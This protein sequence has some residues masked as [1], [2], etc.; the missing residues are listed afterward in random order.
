MRVLQWVV[1]RCE[2]KGGAVETP[3]GRM[4]RYEDLEW[5]GLDT[6]DRSRFEKLMKLDAAQWRT[7][8]KEHAEL[9]GKLKARL[10][11]EFDELRE[12]LEQAL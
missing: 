9:F 6:F 12:Q 8:L 10:P 7:E 1:G 3:L 4:P 11:K 5:T 2:G